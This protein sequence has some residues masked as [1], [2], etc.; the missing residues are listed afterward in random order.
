MMEKLK[1]CPF[2]GGTGGR[3]M[4]LIDADG[5]TEGR[6]ENDPVVIAAK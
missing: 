3:T 4:R 5:M 2:C 6:V 1:P